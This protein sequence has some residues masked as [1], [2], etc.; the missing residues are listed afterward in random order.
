M[1]SPA[2]VDRNALF[3]R[4]GFDLVDDHVCKPVVTID[5]ETRQYESACSAEARRIVPFLDR[6]SGA[7]RFWNGGPQEAR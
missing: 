3:R 5:L 4:D 2:A 7:T 6:P 1:T